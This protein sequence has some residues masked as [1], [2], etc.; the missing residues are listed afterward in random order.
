MRCAH[1]WSVQVYMGAASTAVVGSVVRCADQ[2]IGC[3]PHVLAGAPND[4]TGRHV[5]GQSHSELL[6]DL[7]Q[8]GVVWIDTAAVWECGSDIFLSVQFDA[9]DGGRAYRRREYSCSWSA[10]T[11]SSIDD[12]SSQLDLIASSECT[13][14]VPASQLECLGTYVFG[15]AITLAGSSKAP[16]QKSVSV[17]VR[18]GPSLFILGSALRVLTESTTFDIWPTLLAI[19]P[20]ADTVDRRAR[21]GTGGAP[22]PE[23]RWFTRN[24]PLPFEPAGNTHHNGTCRIIAC[25]LGP[26]CEHKTQGTAQ[27]SRFR[28]GMPGLPL[29]TLPHLSRARATAPASCLLSA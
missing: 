29:A 6:S 24:V 28:T 20:E 19:P 3:E 17:A 14:I 21:E 7:A 22:V 1:V 10:Y 9:A 5:T 8:S 26:G 25:A 23:C 11:H 15:V 18:P 2:A 12:N 16:I 4:E 27:L 13:L